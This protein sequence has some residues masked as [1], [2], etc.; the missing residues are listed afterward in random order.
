MTEWWRKKALSV[1]AIW[2]LPFCESPMRDFSY[3]V[4]DYTAVDPMFG[5][6]D[7]FCRL[8]DKAH[9]RN[10][11]IIFYQVWAHIGSERLIP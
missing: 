9:K 3:D 8:L 7:D 5:V 11:K 10:L 4:S 6:L 2:L 1:D